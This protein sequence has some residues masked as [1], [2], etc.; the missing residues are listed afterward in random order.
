MHLIRLSLAFAAGVAIYNVCA[1]YLARLIGPLSISYLTSGS[2]TYYAL[3]IGNVLFLALPVGLAVFI[4]AA[5]S[6]VLLR[7]PTKPAAIAM[8]IG[9]TGAH[10]YIHTTTVLAVL[11]TNAWLPW[12]QLVKQQFVPPLWFLPST[13]APLVGLF[14]AFKLIRTRQARSEV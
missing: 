6:I 8:A 13:V 14:L 9:M 12:A 3:A 7:L 1:M 4:L 11:A 2:P 10:I 5:I